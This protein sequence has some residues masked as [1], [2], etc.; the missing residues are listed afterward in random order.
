MTQVRVVAGEWDTPEAVVAGDV[1]YLSGTTAKRLDGGYEAVDDVAAQIEVV[2]DRVQTR[3][4]RAGA[5]LGDV[6]KLVVYLRD[7][8]HLAVLNGVYLRRFPGRRP[9]R[10]TVQA[11]GF[12]V[13]AWVELDVIAVLPEGTA[14]P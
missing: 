13:G 7:I 5:S 8:G 1:V 14:V 2:F 12:E 9:A 10:T 3:L 6:V 11:G 4:E